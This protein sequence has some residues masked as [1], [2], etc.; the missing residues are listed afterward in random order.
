MGDKG[1]ISWKDTLGEGNQLMDEY[2]SIYLAVLSNDTMHPDYEAARKA[3]SQGF[4]KDD[5]AGMLHHVN[6][7]IRNTLNKRHGSAFEIHSRRAKG[8]GGIKLYGVDY[9]VERIVLNFESISKN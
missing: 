3:F 1:W 5:W 2:F 8:N 4:G 6:L 7:R 9:P